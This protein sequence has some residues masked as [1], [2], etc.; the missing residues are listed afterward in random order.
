MQNGR[1][2]SEIRIKYWSDNLEERDLQIDVKV[3]GEIMGQC[4][5]NSV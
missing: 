4:C 3:K 5:L 1:D 2:T